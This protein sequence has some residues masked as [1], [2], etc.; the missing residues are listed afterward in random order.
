MDLLQLVKQGQMRMDLYFRLDIL[1]IHIPPLRERREDI[2]VLVESF[3]E[4]HSRKYGKRLDRLPKRLLVRFLTYSW[5][6]NVRELDN[7]IEKLV[8]ITDTPSQFEDV[9][10][11]LFDECLRTEH[12]LFK[13]SPLDLSMLREQKI[14]KRTMA[15]IMGISRTTLWRKIRDKQF[16]ET[17]S[18]SKA[19]E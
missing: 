9:L 7:F 17:N 14:P 10:N 16:D 4:R 1:Q 15:K 3:L 2:P 5:P 8:I 6:G 11:L 19:S 12:V 13:E 18:V